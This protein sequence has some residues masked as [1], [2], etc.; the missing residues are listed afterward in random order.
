[1]T[2][3]IMPRGAV[4][5]YVYDRNDQLI[6]EITPY[7]YEAETDC[8]K[9][10]VYQYDNRGNRIRETNAL[11]ELV[12]ERG[13]NLRNEPIQWTDGVGNCQEM[14]YTLDGRV[15]E[16]RRWR[17]FGRQENA[18]QS[19]TGQNENE[20]S[21]IGKNLAGQGS[22]NQS[23]EGN[24]RIGQSQQH[25]PIQQY[26]Y[27]ARGQIVGIVD[28]VGEKIGYDMDS[29][30]RITSVNFSDGVK[31]GYEYTPSGQVKKTVDGNGNT[32]QY[33]YNSFG[34]VRERIDQAGEKETFQYDEEGNLQLYTDRE[35]NQIYRLYNIFGEPVYEKAADK[36]GENPCLTTFRYDSMGRLVQ[37][38]GNGHS[39]EYEY[40]G[41]GYL[42]EKR[43][44]GKRLISYEYDKAG[45][46]TY[47]TDPAGVKTCYSYDLLGRTSRIYSGNGLEVQYDYDCQNRIE[48]ITYGNGIQTRYEYDRD[49]NL[50]VLE[51][52]ADEKVLFSLACQYDGNGN[53]VEKKG[54][55][56]LAGD[57][58]VPIHTTYQYDIRGQL[59]EENHQREPAGVVFRYGYDACGNRIEKKENS[60]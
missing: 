11:G 3:K 29:W 30:G 21:Y 12:E 44:S 4:T 15:R 38:V 32:V 55:Q 16:V 47:M 45:N 43:S 14:E 20:Q 40:N 25:N 36:N 10:T 58:T 19:Y 39:Y 22:V 57:E 28:G 9:G 52:K 1:M 56:C 7:G 51:T 37:A 23:Q 60:R 31:E 34:K 24:S 27:N 8:G 6:Q 50:A 54:I 41:Q 26:E 35:G 2:H 13:Y 46:I 48:Q 42:K 53:R 59:L 18:V 17:N 5:R 49:G 33:L